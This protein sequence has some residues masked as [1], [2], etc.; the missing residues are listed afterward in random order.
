ML[1]YVRVAAA[2]PLMSEVTA[3]LGCSH[4]IQAHLP[5][6]TSTGFLDVTIHL[7]RPHPIEA[8]TPI[9]RCR[10]PVEYTFA[11]ALARHSHRLLL[12]HFDPSKL[13]LLSQERLVESNPHLNSNT[14]KNKRSQRTHTHKLAL[15]VHSQA[16]Y[17]IFCYLQGW[18]AG[19]GTRTPCTE[20]ANFKEF[21]CFLQTQKHFQ[22]EDTL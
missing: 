7:K 16:A 13:E 17:Q 2:L 6:L 8:S 18:A 20:M 14:H 12:S 4:Q 10:V 1:R 3:S 22:R 11:Q 5:F 19:G 15:L 21:K 9:S